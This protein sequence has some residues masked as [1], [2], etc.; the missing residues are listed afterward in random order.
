MKTLLA[1]HKELDLKSFVKRTA[2]ESDYS[3]LIKEPTLIRDADNDELKVIYDIVN[4]DTK[5]IVDALKVVKYHEGKRTRG[6]VSRSRIFGFRPRHPIRGNYCSSTSL[7]IE[8]PTEHQIVCNLAEKIEDYYSKWYPE[9]Y[10]RHLKM[11][12]EKVQAEWRMNGKSAFTSGIINKNNPLKYHWDTGNFNDAFSMMIVFKNDVQGGYL[13]VPEYDIGFELQNNAVIMFDGQSLLHGVTPIYFA[14]E[15]AHRF[16]V[17]YYSLKQMWKCLEV[18]EELAWA[19][20]TKTERERNRANMTQEH[21][22]MLL[23][24]RGKQ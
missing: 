16:S 14:N 21:R 22:D 15:N 19:R 6:L 20:K 11:S 3:T 4:L 1:K 24:R 13:S 17:V 18:T 12:E 5:E 7:A 23:G 2:L 8:H 9:G 10:Q